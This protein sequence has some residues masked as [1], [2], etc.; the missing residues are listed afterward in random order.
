MNT[1]PS[2]DP[3]LAEHT[4]G[5]D[6]FTPPP[7]ALEHAGQAHEGAASA[8]PADLDQRIRNVGEW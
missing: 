3:V 2:H 7:M 1:P 5:R 6:H 4:F 8:I